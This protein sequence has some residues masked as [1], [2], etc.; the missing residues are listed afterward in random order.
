MNLALDARA[1]ARQPLQQR[2]QDRFERILGESEALL[3]ESGLSGFS[4]PELAKRLDCPRAS[5]YKYFPTH[6]AVLNE[7]VSR[8]YA[9]L[10]GLL[11]RK[12]AR[13]SDLSWQQS[14]EAFVNTAARFYEA[15]P[16]CRLLLLGGAVTD[17][18]YRA[19][20]ITIQHLGNLTRMLL[21]RIG[22]ELPEQPLDVAALAVAI[23][24]TCFRL[25]FLQHK[26]ITRE[27]REEA[28]YAMQAYLSRYMDRAVK[29]SEKHR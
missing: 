11:T 9:E 14:V 17:D 23:G 18:A 12:A 16:V 28:A 21:A 22:V 27:Y 29:P 8:Y 2:S 5:I 19:Q 10:E 24:T 15:N 3:L 7:L 1:Q 20:E 13:T 25:S 26:Q 4:I 6:Y